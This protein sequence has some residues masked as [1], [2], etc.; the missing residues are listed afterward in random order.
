[1]KKVNLNHIK[2]EA[3]SYFVKGDYSCSESVL[4]TLINNFDLGVDEQFVRVASGFSGGMGGSGCTCGTISGAVIAIG[5]L[6]GRSEA[7]DPAINK[8]KELSK[9]IH[10]IFKNEHKAACCRAL[11]RGLQPG[12]K[13]RFKQCYSFVGEVAFETSKI[14]CEELGIQYI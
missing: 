14:I 9:K 1:M 2:K 13:E 4:K 10:D 12:T 5:L 3:E 7:K 11:T 6:F 8:A